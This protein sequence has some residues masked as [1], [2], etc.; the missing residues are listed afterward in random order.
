MKHQI[1]INRL[2]SFSV[3]LACILLFIG[4]YQSE[5]T[6][7]SVESKTEVSPKNFTP[8]QSACGCNDKKDML[9]RIREAEAAVAEYKN[10]I[11]LYQATNTKF[12]Y[13]E[14]HDVLQVG[15]I[16]PKLDVVR[17]TEKAPK[18]NTSK[19]S[20]HPITCNVS[21][22]GGSVCLQKASELHEQSHKNICQLKKN[23][24][25]DYRD[26]MTMAAVAQEEIN[27]YLLEI[28]Y[29]KSQLAK[30]PDTC[31]STNWS[32]YY[33]VKVRYHNLNF[34]PDNRKDWETID[35]DRTYSSTVELTPTTPKQTPQQAQ[36]QLEVWKNLETMTQQQI[37]QT[38]KT[39][40]AQPKNTTLKSWNYQSPN[41]IQYV[42]MKVEIKDKIVRFGTEDCGNGNYD[43]MTTTKT[44]DGDEK[45]GVQNI[46]ALDT[47]SSS[48]TY[49]IT[50]PIAPMTSALLLTFVE[51]R[52]IDRTM[53]DVYKGQEQGFPKTTKLPFSDRRMVTVKG[54]LEN[55]EIHHSVA[56]PFN[57]IEDTLT[58][59]SGWVKA[60]APL[61]LELDKLKG[62]LEV[63]VYYRLSK[64]PGN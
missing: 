6:R 48:N 46:F 23:G 26:G 49:N 9:Y 8:P 51:S 57:L 56:Q 59:D 2:L 37:I 64:L 13:N 10:Q 36:Q 28:N 61:P 30:L 25:A 21:V 22:S 41:Y 11:K 44:W 54:I 19:G 63:K 3:F 38:I 4:I 14:Y 60:D 31:K 52:E 5:A 1:N 20:T 62:K 33:E 32:L 50:I 58:F 34:K 24:A 47:D 40:A 43:D 55:T 18:P 29:L 7:A 16:Q 35:I 42:P 45:D 53:P 12:T 27:G 15:K 17:Q 39:Q